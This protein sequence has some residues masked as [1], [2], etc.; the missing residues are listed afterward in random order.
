MMIAHPLIAVLAVAA[1]PV[2]LLAQRVVARGDAEMAFAY[3]DLPFLIEDL[4][5][6]KWPRYVAAAASSSGLSLLLLG[7]AGVKV[8]V[9]TGVD[10]LAIVLCVDTSGS[11]RSVDLN[12][13]R[14]AAAVAAMQAFVER[15]PASAQFGL[16]SFATSAQVE[17]APTGDRAQ[18]RRALGELPEPNGQTAIGDALRLALRALPST[19]ARRIVL[20][21]DGAN[22]HGSDPAE[23]VAEL[24]AAHVILH[25]IGIG[26]G[27]PDRRRLA[28]FAGATGGTY[29]TATDVTQ[30]RAAIGNLSTIVGRRRGLLDASPTAA[31]CGSLALMIG[32]LAR[33]VSVLLAMNSP[34]DE[35]LEHRHDAPPL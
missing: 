3:S 26:A 19:G 11:M 24:R 14:A 1:I 35:R 4:Q 10:G 16:V 21:T 20:L 31:V 28:T 6:R 9:T 8:P 34:T 7:G 33:N 29:A 30:L 12:P 27:S 13:S 15:A 32:W 17:V 23:A 22:N 5:P 2:Y 18:L 25:A